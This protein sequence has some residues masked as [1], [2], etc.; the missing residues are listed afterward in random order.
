MNRTRGSAI[1]ISL[2]LGLLLMIVIGGVYTFTSYRIQNTILESQNL[3]A[4]A[5]AEAGVS[6]I[7]TE[8]S[9]NYGFRTHKVKRDLTWETEENN[10]QTLEDKTASPFKFSVNSAS[11]GT[12][13]GKLGEGEFK[14]RV[15]MIPYVD[16]PNTK[17][18]DER[19]CY[20]KV[21][22]MGKVGNVV[23]CINAIVQRRY[24]GREFLMYDGDIL[25]IVYGEPGGTGHPNPPGTNRFSVG[26]LYGHR[27]LEIGRILNTRH[28]PTTPGTTQALHNM[29]LISSGLG[30]IYLYNLTDITFRN[31]SSKPVSV[32]SVNTDGSAYAFPRPGQYTSTDAEEHGEYPKEFRDG[33]IP[34]I[35]PPEATKYMRDKDH[36]ANPIPP[37]PIPF[38]D[39]KKQAQNGG[40]LVTADVNYPMPANWGAAAVRVKVLDF[41][42]SVTPNTGAPNPSN[43]V[44][45]SDDDIVIKGNPPRDLKIISAK[46]V[47]IAGDF[48]QAGDTNKPEERYGFPQDYPKNAAESDDYATA[49]AKKL[50]KDD[51]LVTGTGF[52]HHQAVS[53]IA[54]ERIILDYR[55]PVD[56]FENE[57]YPYMKAQLAAALVD[58]ANSAR[59]NLAKSAFLRQG[60]G[61]R[62]TSD[63][64]DSAA[65][66]NHIASFFTEFPLGPEEATIKTSFE[67]QFP[68][69]KEYDDVLMEK[70]AKE[71][72]KAFRAGYE[73]QKTNAGNATTKGYGV[74][75]LLKGLQKE[76]VGKQDKYDDYLYFPEMTINAMLISCGKRNSTFY[77]GPDYSKN[78]D[79]IGNQDL[80]GVGAKYSDF[81]KAVQRVFG[82]EIRYSTHTVH[83]IGDMYNPMIRRKIYDESLPS[84]GLDG[85]GGSG[86]G[87]DNE[88]AAFVMLSWKDIRVTTVDFT[89]F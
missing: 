45:Y 67:T 21:E 81:D 35:N 15:G 54:S 32:S 59:V 43:G 78:Y 64:S 28:V 4:L 53:V 77:A 49:S 66:K 13:S 83:R 74:F 88:V 12:Y 6:C 20:F 22:S 80:P 26:R 62:I 71:T 24:P 42:T 25:C 17:N 86:S 58:Q 11:K 29:D 1:L 50:N 41:G 19:F 72:W 48:N 61:G 46:N 8:L 68:S 34:K 56:C 82:S 2:G 40:L 27:G 38:A 84:L 79:E 57:L 9:Q 10:T 73:G 39:Y 51:A 31:D 89:A 36:N 60:V 70:M 75:E 14:V 18:V 30:G 63:A 23:K 7:I 76:T 47:F 69:T 55:S 33:P 87:R 5:L 52:R 16:N 85:A 44:I 3:K 37:K 65:I